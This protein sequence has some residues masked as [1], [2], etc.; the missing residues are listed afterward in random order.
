MGDQDDVDLPGY[1]TCKGSLGFLPVIK[2]RVCSTFNGSR[3]FGRVEL[4]QTHGKL[5]HTFVVKLSCR[6]VSL[7]QTIVMQGE[8][9]L[10]T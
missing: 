5:L 4:C 10:H 1:I 8:A 7:S 3:R 2:S 6:L 9:C